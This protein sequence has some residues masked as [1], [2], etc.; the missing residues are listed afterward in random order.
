MPIREGEHLLFI[1][2]VDLSDRVVAMTGEN[3]RTNLIVQYDRLS[4]TLWGHDPLPFDPHGTESRAVRASWD[5]GRNTWVGKVRVMGWD[6]DQ[7]G[8]HLVLWGTLQRIHDPEHALP[9]SRARR[10]RKPVT[11]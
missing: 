11:G 7:T 9:A 4:V 2:D 3:V 5:G 6:T 1:D 8:H 10:P